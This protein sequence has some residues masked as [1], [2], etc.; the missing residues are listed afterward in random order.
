M[1]CPI[2]GL[3]ELEP[4]GSCLSCDEMATRKVDEAMGRLKSNRLP[5]FVSPGELI[6]R[7]IILVIKL[8]HLMDKDGITDARRR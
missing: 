7:Y 5:M 2:H 1:K 8:R 3:I 6:D 4:D